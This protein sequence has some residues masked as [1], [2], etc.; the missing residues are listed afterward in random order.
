MIKRLDYEA[1]CRKLNIVPPPP[2]PKNRPRYDDEILG[3]SFFRELVDGDF[4]GMTLPRTFFGRS[5]FENASFVGTDLTE[6]TLCWND[7]IGVDFSLANLSHCDLR[8]SLFDNVTFADGILDGA[9]L[10]R[11]NFVNCCFEGTSM[12]GAILTRKVGNALRLSS[13]QTAEMSWTIE[14]GE[15]P[16]GG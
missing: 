2:L 5:E 16:A 1:S 14:E 11:S 3:F 8:A 12:K 7:F 15:E 13:D 4:S 10:R 6:S 9:D